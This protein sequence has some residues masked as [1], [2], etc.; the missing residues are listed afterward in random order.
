AR[1]DDL[2]PLGERRE[3]EEDGRG[4]V[5]DDEGRLG[6][7]QAAQDGRDVVLPRA[8]PSARE[9][10]LEVRVAPTDLGHPF[11]RR[12]RERRAA[13]VRVHDHAGGVQHAAEPEAAHRG[14]LVDRAGRD[15]PRFAAGPD[16]LP[17]PLE[18]RPGRLDGETV[19]C[20]GEPRVAQQ[21]VHRRQVPELHDRSLGRYTRSA[22][23]GLLQGGRRRRHRTSALVWLVVPALIAAGLAG[24]WQLLK[25][26]GG[27]AV[28][29]AA[30]P[31]PRR[32]PQP[33]R[34]PA[35]R[36]AQSAAEPLL[37]SGPTRLR[38]AGPL[39]SAKGGVL[40]DA[41]TGAVLWAR[42]P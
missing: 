33:Q 31:Q 7:G 30:K 9:V 20:P 28:A 36:A 25:G 12:A 38:L 29:I 39:L 24:S 40:I 4:V 18:S 26:G 3:R 42:Y 6:A 41:G 15:V 14:E 2:A 13:E 11:E 17:R 32:Q 34:T 1:D 27:P 22:V 19:R 23:P 10:V 16:R 21:L 8:A 5:V 37:V 35:P